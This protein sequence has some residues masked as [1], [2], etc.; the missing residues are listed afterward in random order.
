MTEVIERKNKKENEFQINSLAFKSINEQIDFR[1]TSHSSRISFAIMI[2]N[3]S[4]PSKIAFRI[5]N[6]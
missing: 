2:I 5:S 1:K 6:E 3:F 4:Y